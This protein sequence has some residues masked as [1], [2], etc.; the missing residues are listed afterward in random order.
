[1][2][3]TLARLIAA[4]P[5]GF[6]TDKEMPRLIELDRLFLV[7]VRCGCGRFLC[8]AQDFEHFEKCVE[9]GGDYVRDV[10]IPSAAFNEA[11]STMTAERQRQD[12]RRRS[13]DERDCSGAFDGICV[14]SDADPGL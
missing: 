14:T 3:T 7:L 4:L 6:L 12:D 2:T 13:F 9:A 11:I 8:P 5:C 10:S 1:M